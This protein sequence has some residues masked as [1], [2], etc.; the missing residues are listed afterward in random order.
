MPNNDYF[1]PILRGDS[2]AL[3]RALYQSMGFTDDQLRR[4]VIG[5]ANS[6]TDA[7]PGHF[8]LNQ[9]TQSIRSGIEAAGGTAMEFGTIAPCD[10]I[11]EGHA[12]MRSSL[13]ARDIIASSIELMANAHRFDGLVLVGSCDKIVPGMIMAAARLD[14]PAIF[15]G[16][17]PMLPAVYKGKHY[18]GNIV[19]EAVGWKQQGQITQTEF[20][21]IEQLAEPCVGSCAMLGTANSMCCIAEALGLALPGSAAV[22][23]VYAARLRLAR[24]TGEAI[25]HAVFNG[26]NARQILTHKAIE[27]AAMLLLTMGGSTNSIMHLQAI[28]YEAGLG[29]L[30]LSFFDE[31]S[32]KIPQIA[33]VYPASPHDM[34]DFYEAGGV[35]AVL[36]EIAPYLHLD[37]QT[38]GQKTMGDVLQKVSLSLRR[39]VIAPLSQPFSEQSGIAVLAGNLSPDGAVAKPAAVPEH[40]H[41]FTGTACVFNS[42]QESI[43]AI[44]AGKVSPGTAVVLRYEGP[45][46]GP[47]MPEMYRPMK[48]LE[49]MGLSDSCAIVTDGRFSGSN[50]GLFVGHLSPEAS[51]GGLLALV[52][53][54][55]QITIDLP[56]RKLELLVAEE[57]LSRRRKSWKPI[58]KECSGYLDIYRRISRSAAQGAVIAP[59]ELKEDFK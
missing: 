35:P 44:L 45:K 53:D 1:N 17:G 33:S 31:L 27:N 11:A 2:G 19:T 8:N 56:A 37:V 55:D 5:I 9:I 30:P 59:P 57:E 36:K 22:P 6:F 34:T 41:R 24:E 39:E 3:K 58:Q 54:G 40:L 32:K 42:E 28:H 21:E 12:G 47:G 52:C 10:G 7:N 18:D 26:L 43:D 51:E 20:Q 4:P 29:M 23:A 13:P 50:R 16:G 48:S 25:V 46:G 49:G 15:L 14:I 38:I